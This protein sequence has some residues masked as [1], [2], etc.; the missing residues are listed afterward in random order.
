M[1]DVGSLRRQHAR[2]LGQH[3]GMVSRSLEKA[4][5]DAAEHVKRH[6]TFRRHKSSNSLADATKYRVIKSRGGKILRLKWNK[7]YAKPI[8]HGARPH[9]IRP[10]R[11]KVL[12]FWSAKLGRFVFAKKVRHP[13]NRPYHFGKRAQKHAHTKLGK[14]L[15]RGMRDV[16]AR[17]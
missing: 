7:K 10:R 4:G 16:A 13:G 1:F 17:N 5:G 14:R 12:R 6:H 8:E 15:R 9:T 3:K 11:K 2:F